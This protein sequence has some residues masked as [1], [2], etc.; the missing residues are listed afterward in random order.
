MHIAIEG[1]CHGC[2]DDIYKKINEMEIS[3][4]YKIDLLI[5]CGDM[6]TM[7]NTNDMK[8][9][10]ECP[11]K[12][13]HMGDFY[14]YYTGIS[15]APVLTIFI[16]GNHESS[17]YLQEL[18]YGGWVSKNIYYL[19]YS[20]VIRVGGLRIG[21]LSGIYNRDFYRTGHYEIIPY[22][23]VSF[24]PFLMLKNVKLKKLNY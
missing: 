16:G 8:Y 1:C 17:N 21:G 11:N 19:G 24:N 18:P 20:G 7:R 22:N 13:K 14:K 12:Y 10:L 6:E 5:I 15:I 3:N 9:C 4:G 2:L 23:K